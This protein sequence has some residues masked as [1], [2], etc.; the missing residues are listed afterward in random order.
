MHCKSSWIR[1]ERTADSDPQ[2]CE[3]LWT[4]RRH[5]VTAKTSNPSLELNGSLLALTVSYLE[6]KQ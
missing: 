2:Q 6:Y 4:V 3:D 5:N 1:G